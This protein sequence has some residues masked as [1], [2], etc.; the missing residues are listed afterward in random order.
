MSA[1][2]YLVGAGPGDPGLVTVKGLEVIRSA[3]VVVYDELVEEHLLDEAPPGAELI[4]VG[5]PCQGQGRDQEEVN[6]LLVAKGKEGKRVVRLTRGDPLLS[7]WGGEE[8]RALAAQGI[9]F[10]IIPG[11]SE[12][13]AAP[14]YAGIPLIHSGL[15]S[16]VVLVA[17]QEAPAGGKSTELGENLS[18]GGDTL[19]L[20]MDAADLSPIVEELVKGGRS[21]STPVALIRDGT[22]SSQRTVTGTLDSI[23]GV[24]AESRFK[25]PM[26][27][28]V[29]Q[30]VGLREG[31]RWFDRRPLFGKRV[32][33]TRPRHQAGALSRLL[34][35]YGAEPIE[36]PSITIE[37][38]SENPEI[39][40]AI[41]HLSDYQWVIITS[42]NGV[43][44]FFRKVRAQG[45]D[46]RAFKNVSLCAIGPATAEA[47]ER[48]GLS[49]DYIPP[50]YTV[51]G[52]IEGFADK[53][54]RG[55]RILIP[56][57]EMTD[58]GLVQRLTEM[59]A[60]ADQISTYRVR[61]VEEDAAVTRGRQLLV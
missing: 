34:S 53:D 26:V 3:E 61:A 11:V 56:R 42:A 14:A 45:L 15:A 4:C 57:A 17:E 50:V 54:I 16:S 49:A 30:V 55:S 19:V 59:G 58:G 24:A 9:P 51:E 43:E 18:T 5:K 31:C 7:G 21:P 8:V 10:E 47:L 52:I 36:M 1:R 39:D 29:G 20:L 40:T 35:D 23:V 22:R 44:V 46:A 48:H 28:V 33:V 12:G 32:L 2:V 27:M 13:F 38:L 41:Q 60:T 37:E 25:P 6:A